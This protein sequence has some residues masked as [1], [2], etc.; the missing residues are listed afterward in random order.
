MKSTLHILIVMLLT[1]A[2]AFAADSAKKEV[3]TT[4]EECLSMNNPLIYFERLPD[5][6]AAY[7]GA[8]NSLMAR[9]YFCKEKNEYPKSNEKAYTNGHL[10]QESKVEM[11]FSTDRG[12]DERVLAHECKTRYM[13]YDP[14]NPVY[15]SYIS[16][17][18]DRNR[19]SDNGKKITGVKIVF[20]SGV[21]FKYDDG[22]NKEIHLEQVP[23]TIK[24]II[25]EAETGWKVDIGPESKL[26]DI[27]PLIKAEDRD[28]YRVKDIKLASAGK[29]SDDRVGLLLIFDL[30][31]ERN[32]DRIECRKCNESEGPVYG[33]RLKY[34]IKG[35]IPTNEQPGLDDMSANLEFNR[36]RYNY[37][38]GK[39]KE[40]PRLPPTRL[41]I[42]SG[43][44]KADSTKDQKDVDY[45]AGFKMSM[46]FD[47]DGFFDL[48]I[49]GGAS[50][51]NNPL[52]ILSIGI[53]GVDP[54]KR[55]SG[56]IP[57]PYFQST[58]SIDY[59]IPISNDL[60]FRIN[61]SFN[62]TTKDVDPEKRWTKLVEYTILFRD[63]KSGDIEPYMKYT[64]G[65]GSPK[66]EYFNEL[67]VGAI[68]AQ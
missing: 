14:D 44:I 5:N 8:G 35:R 47:I 33:Q 27:R 57:D 55:S 23:V 66:R 53:E 58:G 56:V 9:I 29:D 67:S 13:P 25:T 6:S 48:P 40:L 3:P 18:F 43:S 61:G 34:E 2:Y 1:A 31:R 11:V 54:Q 4:W 16:C 12:A 63:P 37:S 7:F 60:H 64:A 38:F 21:F 50:A 20:P 45:T 30:G 68:L 32:T 22:N 28:T 52:P 62:F 46:I 65:Q 36:T 42:Y 39:D 15:K 59:T 49:P 19:I 41:V 26:D 51:P 10:N 17:S 24:T